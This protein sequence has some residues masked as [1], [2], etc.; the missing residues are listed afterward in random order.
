MQLLEDSLRVNIR[1]RSKTVYEDRIIKK[2][3]KIA[4]ISDTSYKTKLS[5]EIKARNEKW[6]KVL[7]VK[8]KHN[9]LLPSESLTQDSTKFS[10]VARKCNQISS[11]LH[12]SKS[13]FIH[14]IRKS[15]PINNIGNNKSNI[16][17]NYRRAII[18][19][20]NNRKINNLL[21]K[22]NKIP[23]NYDTITFGNWRSKGMNSLIIKTYK[24]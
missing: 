24:E 10:I 6:K 4:R 22:V 1:F 15:Y 7:H 3:I 9:K 12:E 13:N 20:P 2:Q 14:N 19:L 18:I 8:C 17:E 23:R 21:Y 16:V 5:K 11:T